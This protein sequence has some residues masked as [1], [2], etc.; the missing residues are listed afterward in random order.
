MI[1]ARR[2]RE[3]VIM[4]VVS[5]VLLKADIEGVHLRHEFHLCLFKARRQLRRF[6]TLSSITCSRIFGGRD[7][8]RKNLITFGSGRTIEPKS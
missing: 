5:R 1:P 8:G 6:C 2:F 4:G 3:E 7:A